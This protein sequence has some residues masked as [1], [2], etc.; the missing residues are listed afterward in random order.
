MCLSCAN[1][2]KSNMKKMRTKVCEFC[3]EEFEIIQQDQRFCAPNCR[4]KF[5]MIISN[6]K[7]LDKKKKKGAKIWTED[8]MSIML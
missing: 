8:V 7:W 1:S 5:E 4:K 2:R 3:L 6:H